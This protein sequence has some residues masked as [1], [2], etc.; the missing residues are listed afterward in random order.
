MQIMFDKI[1]GKQT[2]S[3]YTE[4]TYDG[5]G[6]ADGINLIKAGM[7]HSTYSKSDLLF[8]YLTLDMKK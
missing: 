1:H 3:F 6:E 4:F 7:V 8:D 2:G 5:R